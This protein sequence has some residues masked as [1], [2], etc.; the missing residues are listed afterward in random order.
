MTSSLRLVADSYDRAA[1]GFAAAADQFVYRLLAAPLVDAVT[2]AAPVGAGVVLDVAAG[3]G[4]VGRRFARSVAVDVSVEQLRHNRSAHL[5]RADGLRLPF[6]SESFVAA[7]CGFGINHVANPTSLILEMAR[8]APVVAVSTWQRPESP[9]LPKQ[10]VF[11]VLARRSGHARSAA[12]DLLDRYTNA[13]GSVDV[14]TSV[15]RVAGMRAQVEV[16]EVEIPWPGVDA[17]LDYRL[18]MPTSAPVTDDVGLRAELHAALASLPPDALTWRPR[19]I[20]GV[21]R[22]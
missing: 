9:Y 2:R 5:V 7:V 22:P 8:V 15:L 4:A 11:D 20:V 10:A 17:Y 14:V 19:I 18:S 1:A 16:A 12:G 3:S 13:V 21:G 6:R